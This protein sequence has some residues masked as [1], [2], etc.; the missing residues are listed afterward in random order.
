MSFDVQGLIDISNMV[1]V[2]ISPEVKDEIEEIVKALRQ[3][4]ETI[5]REELSI[6]SETC[7][8]ELDTLGY[9]FKQIID[10][11]YSKENVTFTESEKA[12]YFTLA[13]AYQKNSLLFETVSE[14]KKKL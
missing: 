13:K 11:N 4:G 14:S 3:S 2:L 10:I 7:K 12:V 1:S 8:G 9:I 6:L 5:T